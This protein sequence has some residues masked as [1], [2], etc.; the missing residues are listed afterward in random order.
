MSLLPLSVR[1]NPL[2]AQSL[3]WSDTAASTIGRLI[4]PLSPSL[5]THV[6]LIPSLPFAARKSLAGYLA[7]ALTGSLIC[8][9]FW[10]NGRHAGWQPHAGDGAWWF[11]DFAGTERGNGFGRMAVLGKPLGLWLS[12]LVLGFGGATVEA[13]GQ[14]RG[15]YS[16]MV[17][18]ILRRPQPG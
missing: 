11:L 15:L 6:P 8:L 7:A 9:G 1:A 16:A 18:L 14:S 13:I 12:A 3:S 5:P 2:W 4:G 10:W 17:V